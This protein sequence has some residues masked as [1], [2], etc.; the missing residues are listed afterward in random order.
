MQLLIRKKDNRIMGYGIEGSI[1]ED[2]D[3][4][5]IEISDDTPLENI[6]W[7]YYQNGDVIFDE[8]LKFKEQTEEEIKVETEKQQMA[9]NE[10]LKVNTLNMMDD[11]QAFSFRYLFNEWQA[12]HKYVK[13]DRFVYSGD[14][15]KVN[16][17]HTSSSVWLLTNSPS[18][19]TKISDPNEEYP[20]WVKPTHAENA[21]SK[22]AK[23]TYNGN[24]YI[25]LIDANVW[26]PDEY[27]AGWQLVF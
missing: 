3:N 17:D 15:Y 22:G 11:T 12:D 6:Y 18:L 20:E 25:S 26:G 2:K 27:P 4:Y 1:L 23:V 19:Y 7:S 10:L 5:V 9:F 21:Y 13:G 8:E 14:F 24:K 16:Q